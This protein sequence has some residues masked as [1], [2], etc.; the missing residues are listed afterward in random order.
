MRAQCHR[1]GPL[2]RIDRGS[3]Q[4]HGEPEQLEEMPQSRLQ[5]GQPVPLWMISEG[6]LKL[7]DLGELERRRACPSD[8]D[9]WRKGRSIGGGQ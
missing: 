7:L 1:R 6:E 9:S 4:R 3:H 2:E 5:R 8:D